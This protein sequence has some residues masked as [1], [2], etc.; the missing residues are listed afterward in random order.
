VTSRNSDTS[1]LSRTTELV[2]F[3]VASKGSDHPTLKQVQ[4]ALH[5]SSPS[6]AMHHLQKLEEASLIERDQYGNYGARKFVPLSYDLSRLMFIRGVVFPK[7][8]IYAALTTVVPVAYV[9]FMA[10]Y[11]LNTVVLLAL[12]PNLFPAAVFWYEAWVDWR[13]MPRI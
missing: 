11:L 6:S 12:L 5:F 7:R 4:N 1:Y 9:M 10:Q 8:L 3:F 13:R 2:Y